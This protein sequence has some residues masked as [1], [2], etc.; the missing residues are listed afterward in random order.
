[1]QGALG[2]GEMESWA[3]A[4]SRSDS[5]R[6]V[7]G[8]SDVECHLGDARECG[9]NARR[10]ATHRPPRGCL[11][12]PAQAR[13]ARCHPA[14]RAHDPAGRTGAG[15]EC[16]DAPPQ[17]QRRRAADQWRRY[18]HRGSLSRRRLGYAGPDAVSLPVL[19]QPRSD[20]G[21]AARQ[22]A[23]AVRPDGAAL[24]QPQHPP[25]G[26]AQH[27][28]PLRHRQC[29]LLGL[30]RSQHDLFVGPVRREHHG[31]HGRADQQISPPRR[32]A[33]PEAGPEAARD[34]LRLGRL[35]RIRRQDFWRTRRWPHDLDRAARL[36]AQAHPRGG[37]RRARSRSGCR[38]IATSGIA[39][40]G[41]LRSR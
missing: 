7:D 17:L 38:I 16:R 1:M 19:R 31:P 15:P 8:F 12:L 28:R 39:T 41:S 32:G 5:I 3:R 34:R 30:A 25:P 4:G 35:R 14:R 26:P 23:D 9:D 2:S 37:P 29:V 13:N 10:S 21:H 20:P 22:A 11:R 33:R 40:T 24:V 6:S 36:R 27:P 18:R